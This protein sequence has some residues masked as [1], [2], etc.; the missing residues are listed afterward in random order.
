MIR[1]SPAGSSSCPRALDVALA[2]RKRER[3]PPARDLVEGV[4]EHRHVLR[5]LRELA[6]ERRARGELERERV[7]RELRRSR[8][9][10]HGRDRDRSLG[11]RR[12]DRPRP[13]V[14][15]LLELEAGRLRLRRRR[16]FAR[17]GSR[18]RLRLQRGGHDPA[19]LQLLEAVRERLAREVGGGARDLHECELERE[20]RIASL[21]HVV[22]GDREQVDEP[23]HGGLAELVRLRAQALP[24]LLGDRQRLGHLAHVL[25]EQQVAEMLDE[26][27][28]EAG[29]RR[30]RAPRGP[31]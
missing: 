22:D 6:V 18:R 15:Q 13:R 7:A 1:S 31:R 23:D 14:L 9:A 5:L 30:A 16:S 27:G 21:A 19:R 12:D 2:D 4:G 11:D 26:V 10:E 20:T 17:L 25:H 28:H 29:P 8:L 3:E 24:R